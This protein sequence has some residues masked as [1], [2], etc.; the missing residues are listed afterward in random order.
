LIE[1]DFSYIFCESQALFAET[2][3]V[4]LMLKKIILAL[5][6][7]LIFSHF[8]AAQTAKGIWAGA[9]EADDVFAAIRLNFDESKIVLSFGGDERAGAIKNIELGK[10]GEIAFAA[11][12]RPAARFT[13]KLDGEKIT[14][15]FEILRSDG[16]KS[17]SGVWSA[18]RVDSMNFAADSKSDAIDSTIELPK[19][20]GAFPIGRKFFYWTDESRPETITDDPNDKRKVFV[21]LWYPAK[22]GG[23]TLAE[24]YPN[25]EE[26]GGKDKTYVSLLRN[27]KT[28]AVQEA[29][30]AKAKTKF[31]V[32]IFS[33]GLGSSPFSYTLI[34]ENLVSQGYVVAAINHPYDSGD[35]K[36]SDGQIIRFASEKWHR[37]TPKDWSAAE[38]NKFFDDR[39]IGWAADI[40]F[41][42]NQLEK[43][44]NSLKKAMDL[45]NLG[46]FGHSFGGQATSIACASDAR[47]KACA[48]LDG[49]A[50]GN[51]VLP[52]ASGKML[53]QP[54]LFFSKA[55][56]VT[57]AELKM[58][59][60]TRGEYRKRER[61]RL[62]TRW[63]PSFKTQLAALESGAY[64]LLYPSIKHSSFSDTLLIESN[65]LPDRQIIA[66]TINEYLTAFFDKFLKNKETPL[67]DSSDQNAS[68]VVVERL[69]RA[70]Q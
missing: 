2:T 49:I 55:A 20:S 44:D 65:S 54:F 46:L 19:P 16:S 18:R 56:E 43:L 29:K 60:L 7:L 61:Q 57:D 23:K 5:S 15:T 42:V 39:R 34:I 69:K 31:P 32:V 1:F 24:Y 21:Q 33:P 4:K 68:P 41:I 10:A 64:F 11:E 25:I 66:R 70:E 53:K 48:N 51:A 50:Q 37:Q 3:E 13:G 27:L 12:L 45:Q 14:G 52:D 36:F 22:A 38:R 59:N 9:F 6:I 47:F 58:M 30:I 26:I 40:S 67:L 8:A 35:F 17:G 63:K 62:T 28:H